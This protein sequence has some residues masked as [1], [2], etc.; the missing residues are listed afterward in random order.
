MGWCR[1]ESGR[2]GQRVFRYAGFPRDNGGQRTRRTPALLIDIDPAEGLTRRVAGQSLEWA[3]GPAFT[4][5]G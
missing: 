2:A 5:Q 1:F 4:R 3:V